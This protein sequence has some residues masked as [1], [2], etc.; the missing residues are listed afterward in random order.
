MLCEQLQELYSG[1]RPNL[2]TREAQEVDFTE[3]QDVQE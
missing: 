3:F 2:N 1:A